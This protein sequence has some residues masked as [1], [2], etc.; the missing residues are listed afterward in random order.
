MKR[1]KLKW[2]GHTLQRKDGIAKQSLEYKPTGNRKIGRLKKT[3]DKVQKENSSEE[4]GGEIKLETL[5]I[6][7]IGK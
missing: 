1:R 4:Y 3:G 7:K 5:S 6:E 2:I